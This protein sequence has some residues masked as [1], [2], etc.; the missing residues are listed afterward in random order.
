MSKAPLPSAMVPL[1]RRPIVERMCESCPFN[2]ERGHPKISVSDEDFEA[3]SQQART[4]EFYCHETVLGDPRTACGVNG[5]AVGVQPHFKV[6]RGGW[7]LKLAVIRDR[8]AKR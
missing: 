5:D 4:G 8:E 3:F 6:C 2:A 7:E 1:P